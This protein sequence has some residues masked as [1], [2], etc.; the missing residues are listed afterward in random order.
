MGGG[1]GDQMAE[2]L[3]DSAVAVSLSSMRVV[4]SLAFHTFVLLLQ[5]VF[6]GIDTDSFG[7]LREKRTECAEMIRSGYARHIA[8]ARRPG[9]GRRGLE[10]CEQQGPEHVEL[11]ALPAL[12]PRQAPRG[13]PEQERQRGRHLR[14]HPQERPRR[15]LHAEGKV[16][17]G[18]HSLGPLSRSLRLLLEGGRESAGKSSEVQS[19][20]TETAAGF[21]REIQCLK[22]YVDKQLADIRAQRNALMDAR[23]AAH[24]GEKCLGFSWVRCVCVYCV[25]V[26]MCV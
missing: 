1:N 5:R 21:E 19:A 11:H 8:H 2:H 25:C 7:G 22:A 16:A 6:S 15:S 4:R 18:G 12:S 20:R 17:G 26:C 23:T 3:G 9:K 10:R 13:P 14:P 24:E